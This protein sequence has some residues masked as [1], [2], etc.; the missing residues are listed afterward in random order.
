MQSTVPIL[1]VEDDEIIRLM[2]RE[3]LEEGGYHVLDA[4]DA[5]H[6]LRILG[7]QRTSL[8]GLIT[9]ITLGSKLNG[10]DIAR[11]AREINPSIPVVYMSGASAH[12]WSALGVPKSTVIAKP[13]APAQIVAAISALRNTSDEPL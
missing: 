10:W 5:D 9:D 1:L 6:A 2:L 11:R 3:A 8:R 4:Q 13:F 7:E 12:H